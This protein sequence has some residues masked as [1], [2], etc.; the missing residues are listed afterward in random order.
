[1]VKHLKRETHNKNTLDM[2]A[3]SGVVNMV[4]TNK[5]STVAD[6]AHALYKENHH[7]GSALL[8]LVTTFRYLYK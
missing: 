3:N 2:V 7:G 1:M 8:Q 5:L 6:T 4:R